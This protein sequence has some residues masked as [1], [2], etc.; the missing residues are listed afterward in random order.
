MASKKN[1]WGTPELKVLQR[2]S[3]KEISVRQAALR[4]GIPRSTLSDHKT[5]KNPRRY[6]GAPTVLSHA[7][8][9]EIVINC[10]VLSEMG[11]P[12]D[13]TYVSAVSDYLKQ[14]GKHSSWRIRSKSLHNGN[15]SIFS[16]IEQKQC[17]CSF[18]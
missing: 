6:G 3:N 5:G 1:H 17:S 11:F 14:H 10:Q 4:Y 18:R 7:E 2:V 9:S 12:S 8:E 13:K 16:R 15:P